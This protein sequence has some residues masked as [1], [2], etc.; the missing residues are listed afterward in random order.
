MTKKDIAFAWSEACQ[1]AFNLLKE[2][3]TSAP[4]LAHFDPKKETHVECDSSDWVSSGV[5]SQYGD[6]GLLH[7]VAFF[8]KKLMDTEC[9]YKIYDKEL[10]AIVQAFEQ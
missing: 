3:V 8:S 2:A 4:V 5:M 6:D 10:L 9:N 1:S 7:S